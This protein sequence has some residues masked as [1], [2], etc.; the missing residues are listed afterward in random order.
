MGFPKCQSRTW[1]SDRGFATLGR[2]HDDLW[3]DP[4][5]NPSCKQQEILSGIE[6]KPCLGK[7][8][9][10]I[11]FRAPTEGKNVF[12]KALRSS[13]YLLKTRFTIQSKQSKMHTVIVVPQEVKSNFLLAANF[14]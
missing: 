13:V 7:K 1:A 12:I 4:V 8:V 11:Y 14:L 5:Q 6:E 9:L 3:L 2:W 10:V